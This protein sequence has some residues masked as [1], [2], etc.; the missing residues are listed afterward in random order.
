[1]SVLKL[2]DGKDVLLGVIDVAT[3]KIETPEE[4]AAVIGQVMKYV[5]KEKI[6][7][8]TNCG[9]VADA[10]RDRG[11]EARSAR[12]WRSAGAEEIRVSSIERGVLILQSDP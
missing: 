8:S 9:M 1:M 10:P 11:A 3:D 4:V 5:A 2:L 12:P 7:P 6:V